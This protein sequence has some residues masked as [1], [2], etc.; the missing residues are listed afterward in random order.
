M[1]K[2]LRHPIDR[3]GLNLCKSVKSVGLHIMQFRFHDRTGLNLRHLRNLRDYTSCS[4]GSTTEQVAFR[5]NSVR[6]PCSKNVSD[7]SA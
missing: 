1:K 5:L 6:N 4:S 2:N 7:N 3:T